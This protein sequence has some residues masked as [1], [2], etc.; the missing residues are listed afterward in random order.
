MSTVAPAAL[1]Q[2]A[3]K[4]ENEC[5]LKSAVLS[6]VVGD[7]SHKARGGFHISREDNP[8]GNFS[9]TRPD[10]RA[11]NGPNN[12]AAAIDMTL[13]TADMKTCTGRLVKV[14]GD[15]NH[16][17][18][19]YINAFNGWQG[20]GSATRWDVYAGTKGYATPD[21]KWHVHLEFRRR[22]VTSTSA[23]N[24]VLA[25]LKGQGYSLK[26]PPYPGRILKRNDA[27]TSP[28]ASLKVWQGRMI[29]R[30]WLDLGKAADGFFGDTTE[31]VVKAIQKQCKV[32]VDGMIGPQ[33]WGLPW[34]CPVT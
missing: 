12:A 33:T 17:A 26:P 4:W 31:Q 3:Q 18:R 1:K 14:W 29:S 9:I 20:S 27:Q 23:L 32:P 8:A 22:F 24:I 16:P 30:G 25:A 2:F 10:D 28:D 5:G 19:R 13:S 21:H 6:G 15:K 34:T 11:G 7:L